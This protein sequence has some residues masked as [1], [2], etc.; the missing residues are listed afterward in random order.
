MDITFTEAIFLTI[1]AVAAAIGGVHLVRRTVSH[2]R[3]R[4]HNEITD[5]M[6]AVLGT[7]FAILLGFM[8]ANSMQRFEEARSN[9][10]AEAGVIGDLFRLASSLSPPVKSSIQGNC[11]SYADTVIVVEWPHMK[12]GQLADAA[13][14]VYGDLWQGCLQYQPQ[15]QSQSN[16]HQALIA[17]IQKLGECR[18]ARAAELHY[19]LPQSLWFVLLFGGLTT[20]GFTFFFGMDDVRL[21]MLMTGLITAIICLNVY[22]LA[23][24]DA[25]F[26][27][28]ISITPIAFESMKDTMLKVSSGQWR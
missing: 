24:Y 7:L 20:I 2:G 15:T 28:D 4:E 5:P 23:G 12:T 22:M 27:G 10:Q 6:L 8:L 13:W 21:H 25:P 19:G 11:I 17:S 9:A 26:S 1:L 3:L 14:N 16:V 18:R